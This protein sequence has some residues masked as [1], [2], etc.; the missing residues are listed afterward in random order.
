MDGQQAIA[1]LSTPL[2]RSGQ[3]TGKAPPRIDTMIDAPR[4]DAPEW[5]EIVGSGRW[6]DRGGPTRTA[7]YGA[8][9]K[10][11]CSSSRA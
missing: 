6:Q 1:S 2:V 9:D 11:M 3:E 8:R 5:P 7:E 10:V 4:L